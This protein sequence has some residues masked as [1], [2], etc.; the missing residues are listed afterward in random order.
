MDS[1]LNLKKINNHGLKFLYKLINDPQC[2]KKFITMIYNM[3]YNRDEI[4][5]RNTQ[6]EEVNNKIEK[7]I[8]YRIKTG[9]L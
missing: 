7:E 3:I 1:R 5:F 4:E 6:F 2:L 9:V 8:L